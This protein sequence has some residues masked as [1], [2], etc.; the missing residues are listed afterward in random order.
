MDRGSPCILTSLVIG[1]KCLTAAGDVW[2]VVHG[3]IAMQIDESRYRR[4][5]PDRSE[6]TR[7]WGQLCYCN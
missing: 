7:D 4:S 5:E 2:R 3:G 6:F 1:G